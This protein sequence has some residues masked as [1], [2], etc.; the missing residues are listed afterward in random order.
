[1]GLSW[2]ANQ[3]RSTIRPFSLL[4]REPRGVEDATGPG[5]SVAAFSF[6]KRRVS[7]SASCSGEGENVPGMRDIAQHTYEK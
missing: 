2:T 5:A 6:F 1:V 3:G 7:R 4:T